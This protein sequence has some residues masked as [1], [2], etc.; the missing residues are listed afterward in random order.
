MISEEVGLM[1]ENVD[2]L[3]LGKVCKVVVIKD[4]IIIVEGVGD[5]DVIVG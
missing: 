1:L 3:L 5:I 4:E 2:L